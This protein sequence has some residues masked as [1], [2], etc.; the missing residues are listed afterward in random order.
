M[1]QRLLV[2][3]VTISL[4]M[5]GCNVFGGTGEEDATPV[6][7]SEGMQPFAQPVVNPQSRSPAVA[8]LIQPTNPDERI[9][10]IK[11]GRSDPFAALVPAPVLSGASS[12]TRADTTKKSVS[13]R[14]ARPSTT[15]RLSA[16][17]FAITPPAST[18]LPLPALS[19]RKTGGAG[20][21]L[22][23]SPLPPLPQPEL[24]RGVQVTGVVLVNGV[25]QAI[26]KAPGET[27]SRSVRPG[28]RLSNG[29]IL[30]KRI[31]VNRTEPVVILEQYGTEI[32]VGVGTAV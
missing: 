7:E 9:R 22:P 31:D 5:G 19:P 3:C 10:V 20:T 25:P 32:S 23:T 17:P 11:S 26:V 27:V 2:A 6:S 28:E 15:V 4:L 8:T 18:R 14:Q 30:V 13:P 12:P 1:G 29:Q 16:N 21:S 24:A